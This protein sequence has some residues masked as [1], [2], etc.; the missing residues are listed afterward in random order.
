MAMKL[1]LFRGALIRNTLKLTSGSVINYI[2]P[3]VTTPILTRI[4][5]PADYGV[6][7][8]FSSIATILTV[9]VCGGYEYAIVESE[10]EQ[11]RRAV[12][13]LCLGICS[14]FN[15]LLVSVF[16][17]RSMMFVAIFITP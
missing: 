4:Y 11:E 1:D 7:G 8:I 14:S 13:R 6:W 17:T 15:L 12:V 10:N 5:S 2:I 16:L 3:M 9:F